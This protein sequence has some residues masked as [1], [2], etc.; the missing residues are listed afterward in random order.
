M[1]TLMKNSPSSRPL[2]GSIWASSSCRYSESA[3]SR[4]AR[5][6]PRAIDTPTSSISHAVPITTSKAVAV[7]TSGRLALATMRNT[8]RNR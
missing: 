3:S 6:A 2:K 4:P 1:P 8:G 5:N 7:E